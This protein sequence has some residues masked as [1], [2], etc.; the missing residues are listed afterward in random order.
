VTTFTPVPG[1]PP[2]AQ[3]DRGIGNAPTEVPPTMAL[4]RQTSGAVAIYD[5]GS[6]RYVVAG[7]NAS[8]DDL[9]AAIAALA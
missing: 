5:P 1:L 3:I 6:D 8:G 2:G 4:Y 9:T 7:M